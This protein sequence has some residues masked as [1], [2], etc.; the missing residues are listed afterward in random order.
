MYQASKDGFDAKDFHSKC[1]GIPNTLTIFKASGSSFIFGL[2]LRQL[3]TV[4]VVGKLIPTLF[5]QPNKQ[6]ES[7]MQNEN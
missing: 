1:D 7:T 3:G 5:V 6:R 2:L 4:K